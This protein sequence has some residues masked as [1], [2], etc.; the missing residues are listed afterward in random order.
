M[1]SWSFNGRIKTTCSCEW[2]LASWRGQETSPAPSHWAGE[3]LREAT[4]WQVWNV[5]LHPGGG[6]SKDGQLVQP[7]NCWNRADRAPVLSL[8]QTWTVELLC[9]GGS[10]GRGPG[11]RGTRAHCKCFNI[12]AP[13]GHLQV[14]VR[15]IPAALLV[16]GLLIRID[17]FCLV[18]NV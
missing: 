3:A 9:W 17:S 12:L 18:V 11:W 13:G 2:G 6:Q 10:L 4:E 14:R 7:W 8:C 16:L 1:S 15:P 5:D